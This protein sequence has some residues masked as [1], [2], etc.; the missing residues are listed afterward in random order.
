MKFLLLLVKMA[1]RNLGRQRRRT[2]I[3]VGAMAAGLA[4]CIPTYALVEGLNRQMVATITGSQLGH[5]QIHHPDYLED[6]RFSLAFPGNA[7]AGVVRRDPAVAAVSPR[8]Y[9]GGMV[10]FEPAAETRL[11]AVSAADR[12]VVGRLPEKAC[13]AAVDESLARVWKLEPGAVVRPFPLPPEPACEQLG[14]SGILPASDGGFRMVLRPGDFAG[15]HARKSAE[16][17]RA[18]DIDDIDSLKRLDGPDGTPETAPARKPSD[19]GMFD[20]GPLAW[21]MTRPVSGQ[22]A[23]IAVD[24]GQERLVTDMHRK[25][26]AGAYLRAQYRAQD[27]LPEI[28]L[29]DSMARQLMVKPGDIVGL[30]V[31][32]AGGFPVDVRLQVAGVFDSGLDALDRTLAFVHIGLAADPDVV[33]LFDPVTGAPR[34]HELAVR[35]HP[36][37]SEPAAAARLNLML[38]CWNLQ[39]WPWQKLEPSLASML[40]IQDAVVAI[41]LLIIFTIAA[42]GTMNTMLMSVFERVREFGVLKSVGMRPSLVAGLI[43]TESLFMTLLAT[44]AGGV[45]GVVLSRYLALHGLDFSSFIPGGYRYQGILLDPVWYAALTVRSVVVP[46]AILAAVGCVVALWPALRA[47]RIRPVEAFRQGGI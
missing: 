3:T 33:G 41:L 28:L 2:G 32:S 12:A 8:V 13:E 18:P 26:V 27:V 37:A 34:V 43:L 40:R 1:W 24:P 25:V 36:G 5:V 9:T 31:M 29:G 16:E 14:V 4:L 47:A 39:A 7:V 42:L 21:K 11:E 46:V 35:L 38:S 15:F 6:R 45:P 30:D 17:P 23:V 44:L 22:T 19:G 10:S 20:S